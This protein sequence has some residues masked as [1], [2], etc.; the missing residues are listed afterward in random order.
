MSSAPRTGTHSAPQATAE[1][2]S[3]SAAAQDAASCATGVGCGSC[4]LA[5]AGGCGTVPDAEG[6]ASAA[7]TTPIGC[8]GAGAP[9][10]T[11]TN[12]AS[13]KAAA[14]PPLAWALGV[15]VFVLLGLALGGPIGAVLFALG[16]LIF[17]GLTVISW[18]RLPLPGKLVRA[19]VL[20]FL[21]GV[22]ILRFV[23]A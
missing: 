15:S 20:V 13:Q 7:P 10:P 23:P 4:S 16:A 22:A 14:V 19:A 9:E 8:G 1:T 11:W 5:G 2:D 6:A 3:R 12:R 21:L 17:V 18:P